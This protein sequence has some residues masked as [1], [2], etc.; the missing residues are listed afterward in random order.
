[1]NA[2]PWGRARA[3]HIVLEEA[4]AYELAFHKQAIC[5]GGATEGAVGELTAY[6]YCAV[7]EA[8]VPVQICEFTLQKDA[9]DVTTIRREVAKVAVAKYVVLQ[10]RRW[11]VP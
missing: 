5:E 2:S 10:H 3:S 6:K 1:M 9:I 7:E 11:C 4:T 8:G